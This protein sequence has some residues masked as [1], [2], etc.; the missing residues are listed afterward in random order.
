[1]TGKVV[2]DTSTLV[3][4]ALR[5]D[6]IPDRALTLALS[7]HLLCTSDR[8]LEELEKVLNKER[9]DAYVDLDSRMAL[10]ATIRAHVQLF[11]VPESLQMEARGCCRDTKDEFIL[12]L[13]LASQADVIV[14]SDHDL[15]VL[16]PWRGLSILTPA[17]FLEQFAV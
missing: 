12:A 15:L 6:S 10:V 5:A 11:I 14:S 9:F 3:S 8:A 4:A 16:H 2:L 13:A 1:M 7:S 17:Q